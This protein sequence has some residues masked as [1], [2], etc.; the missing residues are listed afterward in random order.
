M[1]TQEIKWGFKLEQTQLVDLIE[2]FDRRRD[3]G[4]PELSPE[5]EIE[6]SSDYPTDPCLLY[7]QIVAVPLNS[8]PNGL[9]G[10]S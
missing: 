6:L 4:Q 5:Y 3:L 1:N 10:T 8:E 9:T 2:V 7:V